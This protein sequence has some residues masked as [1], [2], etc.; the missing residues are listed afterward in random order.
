MVN[1]DRSDRAEMENKSLQAK[2]MK[3]FIALSEIL[4]EFLGSVRSYND[5]RGKLIKKSTKNEKN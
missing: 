4:I 1:D 3:I 5:V 2:T